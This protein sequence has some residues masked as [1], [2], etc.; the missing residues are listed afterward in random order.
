MSP[1]G[2]L[3]ISKAKPKD[4]SQIRA[5]AFDI[6][7]TFSSEGK[8]TSEAFQALWKLHKKGYILVPVTGRPAGWCDHIARFWPVH[9]VVGENGAF[10]LFQ[11]PTKKKGEIGKLRRIETPGAITD[12]ALRKKK[13][14]EL[15]DQIIFRFPDAKFASDQ[16][17]RDHDLAIDFCE[18]VPAWPEAD[19]NALL[20]LCHKQGAHAKL[21]SI[22]VN[23]WFGDYDKW[24]GFTNLLNHTQAWAPA[25]TLKW[26]GN[27]DHWI[28]LGDSPNDE[29]MFAKFKTS[30]AMAN[31]KPWLSRLKN[32][33]TYLATKKSGAGFVE[34]TGKLK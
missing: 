15:A 27:L 28:F 23:T 3:S 32:Y 2:P 19:V 12:E 11:T 10:C 34:V 24:A 18:D 1:K 29:P 6:D 14:R 9:A 22:H 26:I 7:D 20:E 16:N 17:Y 31:L 13:L 4:L 25:K 30:A 21:S 33:P 5:V 8:I